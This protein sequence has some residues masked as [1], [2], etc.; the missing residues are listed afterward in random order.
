M[1]EHRSCRS[2][3]TGTVA[4]CISCLFLFAVCRG[5]AANAE[6]QGS[7]PDT[8]QKQA[9]VYQAAQ[10]R[11][12]TVYVKVPDGDGEVEN[13]LSQGENWA[14][15]IAWGGAKS[16]EYKDR[17]NVNGQLLVARVAGAVASLTSEGYHITAVVPITRAL[18]RVSH[19][20]YEGG[21]WGFGSSPT[22]GVLI[23]GAR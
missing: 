14:A 2:A 9:G 17:Y 23:V 12:K 21:G 1:R 15:Q 8:E 6:S 3:V 16:Q 4:L 5:D 18:S 10:G 13:R 22:D 20:L 7:D 19:S 11:T